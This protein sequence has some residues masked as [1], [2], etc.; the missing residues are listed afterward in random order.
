VGLPLGVE[1]AYYVAGEIMPLA[2]GPEILE[3]NFPPNGQPELWC[4]WYPSG[5]GESYVW[6]N[7][8]KNYAYKSWLEYLIAHFFKPWHYQL[9][10]RVECRY[11]F[12]KY[13]S[14]NDDEKNEENRVEIRYVEKS[15]LI[16]KDDNIVIENGLGTF[17][18]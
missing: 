12:C 13:V 2:P 7:G 3:H 16:V 17:R 9:S 4:S 14:L 6:A 1:G 15:E 8:N 18:D 5:D 10:G 11:H